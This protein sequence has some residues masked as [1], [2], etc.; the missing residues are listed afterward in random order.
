MALHAADGDAKR[1][2]T[3]PAV[4]AAA[5]AI[6]KQPFIIAKIERSDALTPFDQILTRE[7]PSTSGCPK[8]NFLAVVVRII[9]VL[10]RK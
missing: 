3:N 6:G 1:G 10:N 8:S 4:R 9:P 5:H 2:G 7:A